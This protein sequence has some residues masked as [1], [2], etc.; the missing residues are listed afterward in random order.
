MKEQRHFW[1]LN[2]TSKPSLLETAWFSSSTRN[3]PSTRGGMLNARMYSSF[4]SPNLKPQIDMWKKYWAC[5]LGDMSPKKSGL[6]YWRPP[7]I[8]LIFLCIDDMSY[9]ILKLS[10]LTIQNNYFFAAIMC[11]K[12]HCCFETVS[13]ESF[14][15]VQCT[16]KGIMKWEFFS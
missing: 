1:T 2:V 8:Y 11:K 16:F 15:D 13:N 12:N 3:S 5:M 7:L 4:Q 9:F 14:C 6:F 10:D